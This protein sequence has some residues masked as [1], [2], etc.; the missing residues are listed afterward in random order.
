M[1]KPNQPFSA[2][3]GKNIEGRKQSVNDN[4]AVG[5]VTAAVNQLSNWKGEQARPLKLLN[6]VGYGLLILFLFD[7]I[8]IFSVFRPMNPEWEL[9]TLGQL[10]DR[11]AVPLIGFGLVF[12]GGLTQRSARELTWL[13]VLSWMTL[14]ATIV[15]WLWVPLGIVDTVRLHQGMQRQVTTQLEKQ[16]NQAQTQL[17]S[18]KD[19]L[20]K[21]SSPE[22]LKTFLGRLNIKGQEAEDAQQVAPIKTQIAAM[23]DNRVSNIAVQ[24]QATLK[25]RQT[26]LIKRSLK[27]NLS[28]LV[29]GTLFFSF[30]RG[31]RWIRQHR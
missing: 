2:D 30:W 7:L 16:T 12:L 27:W 31:T 26:A 14:L 1:A 29:S 22:E 21:V 10:T 20:D 23:L 5:N 13:R 3:E 8:E 4:T 25:N 19:Q 17:K 15:F 9:K 28:S 6:W 24:A 18:V 11:V